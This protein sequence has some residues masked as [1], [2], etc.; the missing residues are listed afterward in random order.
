MF[1]F[2]APADRG[3]AEIIQERL[4]SLG[5]AQVRL[6]ACGPG[7]TLEDVWEQGLDAPAILLLLSPS[8]VPATATREKWP[9]ILAHRESCALPP[10]GLIQ[11]APCKCP[12]ILER[13]HFFRYGDHPRQALRDLTYWISNLQPRSEP[14][15]QAAR[16]PWFQGRSA[17]LG[18]L[19]EKL[20]D[21]AGVAI[22]V[23]FGKTVLAQE[24]ARLAGSHFRDVLWMD[25]GQR[26]EIS[27]SGELAAY[28]GESLGNH[29]EGAFARVGV[30]IQKRRVLLVLDDV[31]ADFPAA[32]AGGELASVLVTTG[33]NEGAHLPGAAVIALDSVALPTRDCK[34]LPDAA[35][36]VWAA[37]QACRTQG[38]P[39]D[40]AA[41]VAKVDEVEAQE[42]RHALLEGR[43]IDPLDAA[44]LRYRAAE[45]A[46][47][48]TEAYRRWHA[49]ALAETFAKWGSQ[50]GPCRALLA[51]MDAAFHWALRSNWKIAT[52]LGHRAAGF[53]NKESRGAEAV[54]LYR[55]LLRGAR[56]RNDAEETEHCLRELSWVDDQHEPAHDST[57]HAEQIGFDFGS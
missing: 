28:L 20:V 33:S 18:V 17:E 50:P 12:P 40:L 25:C 24:F 29:A 23:G 13:K 43:W 21:D 4:E 10:L 51:E 32:S 44:G 27:I 26:S 45:R 34:G 31:P 35:Q 1:L 36:E 38:F 6:E 48:A 3:A 55:Q 53:L 37:I 5:A 46:G 54:Y 16:L 49:E 47:I 2:H 39:F 57:A 22:L 19:W 15:F 30:L 52:R 9:T 56:E 41:R 8:S 11:M 42:A 14:F 7:E